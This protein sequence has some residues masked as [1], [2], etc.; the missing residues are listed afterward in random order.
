MPVVGI[1]LLLCCVAPRQATG[2]IVSFNQITQTHG[3]RNGNVRT[4]V[5]DHQ[6]FVWIGTEDGLHRYDGYS[7]KIY[8]KDEHDT[9]S[10][11]SNFILCLYEDSEKNLWIG[12][13]DGSLCLYN[14]AKDNFIR[15][16]YQIAQHD[17]RIDDGILAIYE[18]HRK[19]LFIGS[20]QLL[21]A[22]L[23][24][25]AHLIRFKPVGLPTY[26]VSHT[27]MRVTSIS[28]YSDSL[29]LISINNLGLYLY[30]SQTN[31]FT[32]HPISR[33]EKNIQSVYL[34]EKRKL[35]WSGTWEGGLLVC[36]YSGARYNRILKGNDQHSLRSNYVPALTADAQGNVWAATDHGLSMIT[37]WCDPLTDPFIET[38]L[39]DPQN[40][41]GIQ[42]SIIKAVYTDPNDNLWVG[43]Y[44]NGISLYDKHSTRFGTIMLPGEK[45]ATFSNF[46]SVTGLVEDQSDNL[47]VGT[48]GYGLYVSN[49]SIGKDTPGFNRITSC[50]GI[51]KI[52]CIK[53]DGNGNLWI[54]TW[55]K[56]VFIFNMQS[57]RCQNFENLN[58]GVD[59]GR[60]ILSLETDLSGNVWIGTFDRGF[61]KYNAK[62]GTAVHIENEKRQRNF[63]D[64]VNIIRHDRGNTL[65]VGKESGGLNRSL[66]GSNQYNVV[67]SGHLTASTTVSS[68]YIDK[69]GTLWVGCPSKGL[70][71]YD[72]ENDTTLLF[73]EQDGLGNSMICGIEEDAN[74]RLWISTDA[75]ISVFNKTTQK[76]VNFGLANGLL[77]SQFN[78]GSI[79]AMHNGY[80]VFGS[81]K[82][83]N[84]ISPDLFLTQ[85]YDHPIV[86]T[87]LLVNN[88][89][90]RP[91]EPGSVLTEN[92]IVTGEVQLNHSQ[93]SFSVEV[94][95]LN[96][97][98]TLRPEYYYKLEGFNETWQYA[99]QQRQIQ[100][101]NL[102]PGTYQ[103]K[104]ST[105]ETP[106]VPGASI[107]TLTLVIHPAWWQTGMFHTG[108]GL[109]G[110][111]IMVGIHRVRIRYLV[112]IK[113]NLEEQV[114]QR[115]LKL[116]QA[117]DTLQLKL[118]EINAMHGMI[119]E[120]NNEIQAQNEEL[121]S[122]NEHIGMQHE[123]L[124]EAQYELREINLRLEQT[125][126][127]RTQTLQQTINHLN[128]IV[129]E[130]DRFVYS[131][132]HDLS[133][134]LK[135]ILG[136]V[137]IIN[138]EQDPQKVQGY[139]MLIKESVLKLEAVIK[140]M[141]HYARNA[142]TPLSTQQFQL[143]TLLDDVFHQLAFVPG[144]TR[145]VFENRIP[146]NLLVLNDPA[147]VKI[148]FNNL[149]ENAIKYLDKQKPE[150]VLKLEAHKKGS[151]T[152]VTVTD[153]GIG[154][155]DEFLD[156]VFNMYYRA[157]E[158]SKGSGLG[159]FIVKETAGKIGGSVTVYSTFGEGT[160][161]EVVIPEIKQ[162]ET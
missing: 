69:E 48:D 36:D 40:H 74:N 97:D 130:L 120:K 41:S 92:I 95:S 83:I 42:G 50:V 80:F 102:K 76:F 132:S 158:A 142:H 32:M 117:N 38:Y 112:R 52:K 123:R 159:L 1:A 151:K 160:T 138:M 90:Q 30:N 155:R 23:T 16:K 99:G 109:L 88:E 33:V 144:A 21:Q 152:I 122:Q 18:N 70:V 127:E 98:F 145:I 124:V 31:R 45:H 131:A 60:E 68:L 11:S 34:D 29:L 65:W 139:V 67:E 125:V 12:T 136:L 17:S 148:I 81:I 26:T 94:A 100:Y 106:D 15:F 37:H 7:M 115:T 133:A 140:S 53:P 118:E 119:V 116:N 75:G 91:N 57:G 43:A 28:H 19:Q 59:I 153:N 84:Y 96:F 6:G 107:A 10:I 56:G 161:F 147:R 111:L 44:Y 128:K 154:I 3:L 156:K 93:N 58:T 55:G 78:K 73:T 35:V 46:Q 149:I 108:V 101:T 13:L 82:G 87:K 137:Q 113:E 63:I 103:L 89:D 77:S 104:V 79:L 157:T 150:N 162:H 72:I 126:D 143:S 24:D 20:G 66:A 62:D 85:Q 4:I 51:E 135:S 110:V 39:P 2:Q 71:R 61:F 134:P 54:G 27:G 47:W 49:N 129:F 5:K 146:E 25:S 121:I 86:F 8:R 64:R 105:S 9:T 14:R 141:V 114:N 22:S